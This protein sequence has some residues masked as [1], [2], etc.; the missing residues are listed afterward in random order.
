[1]AHIDELIQQIPDVRLRDELKRALGALKQEK[2]FGLVFEEHQPEIVHLPALKVR[3]GARVVRAGEAKNA[4][5]RVLASAGK[6][7]WR[8]V[9]EAGGEEQT[10][11]ESELTVVKRFGEP[12]YPTLTPI[13]RVERAPGKSWHTVINADNFH[14]LQLLLYCYEGKVDCIYIDPPYNSRARDWKYNNDYV[15]SSDPFRHSKWLSMM[16]R[17]LELAKRLLNPSDAVLIVTI[18]EK[19]YQRLALLLEQLFPGCT[20]QMVT[21]VINPKGTARYNEFSRVEEYVFFVFIGS[22][23]LQSTGSDMLTTR[24]YTSESDVR[25]RGLARTGRKGLRSNNPGSW[26]PIFLNK[27][28]FSIHSIGDAIGKDVDETSVKVPDRTVAV[29]PPSKDGHQYSWSTVPETLRQIYAKGGFK[30]GRIN[31]SKSS[32]PFYYLSAGTFDKIEKGEIIVTGRG[33]QNELVIEFAEGAKS[34]APRSVWNQVAHDAG[35][36]GTSLLQRL[37]PG[38][39]F[40]FPKSLYAV[41]DALRFFIHNKLDALILD[42]FGGSGTTTHAVFRL[43]RQDGRRRRSILVTNNEVSADEAHLLSQKGFRPSDPEWKALG[44]FEQVTRPR[45]VSALTGKTPNG[46]PI[47]GDYKFNDEGP[48]SEGFEENVEFFALDFL[49]PAEVARGERFDAI[50]PILWLIAGARGARP[51]NEKGSHGYGRWFIPKASPFAVLLREEC[52]GEF[53]RELETRP[54]VTHVFLVTDSDDGFREM[55]ALV[56]PDG[57]GEPRRTVQLYRSYLE[58]FRINMEETL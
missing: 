58:N 25:W 50:V 12:I 4:L 38:R 54:D 27:S 20:I 37:I 19:E 26:Y 32:F 11:P 48:M 14:A 34:A 35:S 10:A 55:A 33:P 2:K 24:D 29:W 22:A 44:I 36:H 57:K 41:E 17:R 8:I 49:D 21:V 18:D 6:D 15:D 52:L 43:N 3:P 28:D 47:S 39:K 53:L 23:R 31:P 9:P 42:F 51:D 13:D 30:T 16:Q 56:P 46:E 7:K 1:M 5:W 45:I 40:P